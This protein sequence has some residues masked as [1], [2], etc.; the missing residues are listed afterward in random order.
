MPF[1]R[2]DGLVQWLD[3]GFWNQTAVSSNPAST[4]MKP[5]D[6]W[7]ASQPL[8]SLLV[9]SLVGGRFSDLLGRAAA[10]IKAVLEKALAHLA[11]LRA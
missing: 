6:F 8:K 11:L 4:H 5:R 7:Q 3:L 2:A 9:V 1:V 10:R